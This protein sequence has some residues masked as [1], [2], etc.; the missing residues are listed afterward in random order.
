MEFRQMSLQKPV[1]RASQNAIAHKLVDWHAAFNRVKAP[2][3]ARTKYHVRL[4]NAQRPD[5]IW[6]HFG[7]ILPIAVQKRDEI[8]AFLDGIAESNFLVASVSLIDRVSK[9][10][11]FEW[12]IAVTD[13]NA[14][15]KRA[16]LRAMVNY[17][18]FDSVGFGKRS[19]NPTKD[20]FK[21]V[22]SAIGNNEDKKSGLR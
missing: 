12:E 3:H 9:D 16:V 21:R 6:K 10:Y 11:S 20:V 5:Q 15:G 1:L 4:T 14:N 2:H 22:L 19:G 7:G 17:E 18:N 13:T 8:E